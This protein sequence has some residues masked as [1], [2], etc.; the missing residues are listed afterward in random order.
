MKQLITLI[1]ITTMILQGCAA[2]LVLGGIGVA[3]SAHDRRSVGNQL[4]D[5]TL[6][7][8]LEGVIKETIPEDSKH[9]VNISVSIYNG[10]V[11]LTGQSNEPKIKQNVVNAVK[12]HPNIKKV[13]DQIRDYA[14]I[15]TSSHTHDV[16]LKSKLKSKLILAKELDGLHI[17]ITVEDSEV[18]LMGIVT[19]DE[20]SKAVDIARNIDGVTKVIRAFEY[21]QN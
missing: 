1:L 21:L 6:F 3:A 16:W 18:F 15:P 19:K 8:K 7:F 11:L 4:D 2:G 17:G 10:V 13:F 20:A 5:K 9:Q 12:R 14:P